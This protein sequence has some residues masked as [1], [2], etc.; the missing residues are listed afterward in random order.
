[1][2]T[3]T[4]FVTG[5]QGNKQRL[6]PVGDLALSWIIKYQSEALPSLKSRGTRALFLSY[7]GYRIG[8]GLTGILINQAKEYAEIKMWGAAHLLR[9]SCATH[10]LQ[11]GADLRIIQE[12]LCHAETET[13]QIYTH[14]DIRHL[15]EVHSKTHPAEIDSKPSFLF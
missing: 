14:L 9:H 10:M 7:R 8:A 2:S 3:V 13:T 5:F 6:V 4:G 1:M 12:I 11:N 15:K